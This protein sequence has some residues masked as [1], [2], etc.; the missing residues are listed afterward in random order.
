MHLW[1]IEDVL[2]TKHGNNGKHFFTATKVNGHNK[3][4]WGLWLQW[5]FSHLQQQDIYNQCKIT[6]QTIQRMQNL[7]QELV[8]LCKWQI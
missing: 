8:L 3:H 7:C 6:A 1:S 2:Y 4:L 5:E